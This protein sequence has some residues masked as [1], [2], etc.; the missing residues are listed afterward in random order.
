[1]ELG[2]VAVVHRFRMRCV[3]GGPADTVS[4]T[5]YS[6]CRVGSP[7]VALKAKGT[8]LVVRVIAPVHRTQTLSQ[9]VLQT[10]VHEL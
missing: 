4:L 2:T 7:P 1:M 8:S 10:S 9:S 3:V 5:G 6:L